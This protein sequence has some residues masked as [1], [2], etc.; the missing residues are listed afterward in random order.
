MGGKPPGYRMFLS[1]KDE[2]VPDDFL[3][4]TQIFTN[5]KCAL[6]GFTPEEW[7]LGKNKLKEMREKT[8]YSVRKRFY[9][10]GAPMYDRYWNSNLDAI[11]HLG[12]NEFSKLSCFIDLAQVMICFETAIE[13]KY[14]KGSKRKYI[15]WGI[16][17]KLYR[18][19]Y[20]NLKEAVDNGTEPKKIKLYE[21]KKNNR[22]KLSYVNL[23]KTTAIFGWPDGTTRKVKFE[24]NEI[25][26]TFMQ[27]SKIKGIERKRALYAAMIT[28]MEKYPVKELENLKIEKRQTDIEEVREIAIQNNRIGS[29]AFSLLMPEELNKQ[30]DDI[31]QRFNNDPA[32]MGEQKLYKK[33]FMVQALQF[34]IKHL[35]LKYTNPQLL[36]E[37]N[38]VKEAEE[39]NRKI[40]EKK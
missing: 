22:G 24:E 27:W 35:P 33:V 39:Y 15:S 32:N 31:V 4:I 30:I 16:R 29:K 17:K 2:Y 8:F 11:N 9:E 28:L 7:C 3:S 19:Y 13:T 14:M 23:P 34:Y 20:D 38:R 37:Y 25:Y 40:T 6:P 26:Y 18:Q 21:N 10:A 1:E 12:L 5:P 36:D